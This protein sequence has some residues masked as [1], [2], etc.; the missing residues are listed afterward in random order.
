MSKVE[1]SNEKI[2]VPAFFGGTG[3]SP[4]PAQAKPAWVVLWPPPKMK[5]FCRGPYGRTFTV[6]PAVTKFSPVNKSFSTAC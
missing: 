4:V 1:Y 5:I 2:A 3:V 6:K